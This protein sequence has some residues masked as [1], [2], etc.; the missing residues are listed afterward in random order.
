MIPEPENASGGP[1]G[2]IFGQEEGRQNRPAH[3][4]DTEDEEGRQGAVVPLH[5]P[6]DEPQGGHVQK[7]V[8]EARMEEIGREEPPVFSSVDDQVRI[9]GP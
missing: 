7:K 1:D 3:R 4:R 2:D 9:F 8:D 6:A 5:R